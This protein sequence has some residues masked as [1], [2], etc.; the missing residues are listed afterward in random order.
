MT[1]NQEAAA[2][3]TIENRLDN[4]RRLL[5]NDMYTEQLND[6]VKYPMKA[7]QQDFD[8]F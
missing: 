6:E 4:I 7:T 3:A 5:E 8:R 2:L 1:V